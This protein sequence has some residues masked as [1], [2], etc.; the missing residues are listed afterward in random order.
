MKLIY[1][2]RDRVPFRHL[3]VYGFQQMMAI[4]TATILIS[5]LCGTSISAGLVAGGLSTLVFLSL[6]GFRC[7]LFVSNSGATV[8]AVV[9]VAAL[10]TSVE[11]NCTGVV[12]GGIIICLMNAIAAFFIKR[13]GTAWIDKAL[14]PVVVGTAVMLIGINLM[15]FI[16]TYVMIDGE[17]SLLGIGIALFTMVV[18]AFYNHYGRG[19]M[20]TLSLLMGL[21]TAYFLCLGLTVLG[22]APLI[23]FDSFT[24]VRLFMVPDFSFLHLDFVNFDWSTLPAI[25]VMFACVNIGAISEHLGDILTVSAITNED[26]TKKVG[27]HRT[28][29]ADGFADLVGCLI[30]SQP[31]TTYGES[32][33]TIAVSRVASTRVLAVAACMT[34]ALG[35]IGPFNALIAG[36][37]SFIFGGIAPIAYGYIA[38]SGLKVLTSS[39][40]NYDRAKNVLIFAAMLSL[41]SSGVSIVLGNF[42]LSGVALAIVVGIGLNLILKDRD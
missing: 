15:K 28:L 13:S 10:T 11:Q 22:V 35:F 34:A 30:G 12:I 36:M 5:T 37:P 33:A 17:Y 6:T 19:M 25:M 7:P 24:N 41:G 8:S 1:N 32:L 9:G 39:N 20:P 16:P 4:L 23:N 18:T 31:T 27:L 3:F 21:I 14:P 29:F 2:I 38:M 40:I 42:T 26:L